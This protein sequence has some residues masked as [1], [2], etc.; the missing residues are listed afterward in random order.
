MQEKE[1]TVADTMRQHGTIALFGI[2]TNRIS[3]MSIILETLKKEYFRLLKKEKYPK[4]PDIT[5]KLD[6]LEQ[7]IKNHL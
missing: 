6:D 1:P 3:K 7:A 5:K 2:A 4:T